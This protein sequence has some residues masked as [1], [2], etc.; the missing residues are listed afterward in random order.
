[1]VSERMVAKFRSITPIIT[2]SETRVTA[3]IRDIS[4]TKKLSNERKT[5]LDQEKTSRAIADQALVDAESAN[6]T[7]DI[8]LATLS[9]ELRTPLTSILSYAQLLQREKIDPDKIKRGL[10]TIEKSA[11]TQGQL[12]DDLL[13]I[14][15]IQS[16]KLS[17]SFTDIDPIE[18]VNMAIEAVRPLAEQKQVTIESEMKLNSEIIRG[19]VERLQ[20]I[21]W[22]LLTNAIKFSTDGGKINVRVEPVVVNDKKF[23]SIKVID[24]GKGIKADFLPKLFERFS[25]ADSSSVRAH[26]GL[27]LG[28]ALVRDLTRLQDGIVRAESEGLGKGSTFTVYL[29]VKG[30]V[31]GAL[32][33]PA[34]RKAELEI[35]RPNLSGLCVMIVEDDPST[36]EALNETLTSF[37]AKTIQCG[38]VSA[39]LNSFAKAKPDVLVSDIAMP[40]EDGIGLIRKIRELS[41]QQNGDIP[42]LAL[43]AY[44]KEDD[45]RNALSAGFTSHMAK[46]FDTLQLG[47]A[48]LKL[49]K[50]DHEKRSK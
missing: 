2:G 49:A 47:R 31:V 50:A 48:V 11:K 36:M 43:T 5:L 19:D 30:A 28:L 25:Q 13:D 42:S 9:H 8:F 24:Y 35:E 20:Q 3:I 21:V 34:K 4:E 14:S 1:L 33:D 39:A 37:G 18:P 45:I 6:A 38:N 22:N 7:K 23:V 26:G 46:P 44:A 17:I 16:G 32:N 10:Q 12:I 15:R 40:G 27:G 41:H 29:P